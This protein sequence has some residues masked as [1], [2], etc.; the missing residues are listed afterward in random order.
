MQLHIAPNRLIRDIQQEFNHEF[1]FLKLEFFNKGAIAR[2]DYSASQILPG[3]RKIAEAQL[4]ITDGK[5]NID[6]E[7]RVND[8]E[9]KLQKEFSLAVQVFRKSGKLW[10]ETTMTD[11]W[12]LNQQNSHGK[13]L[14]T[15]PGYDT[16]A[17]DYDL[18]SDA[19]H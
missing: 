16:R 18:N 1:A 19:D 6:G 4:A 11:A 9:K 7:M 14:S 3:N 12:T 15:E 5:V 2:A 8:L 10:L 13:E 17:V